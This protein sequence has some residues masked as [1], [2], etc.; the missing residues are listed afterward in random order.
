MK[1]RRIVP[2]GIYIILVVLLLA[3]DFN[4]SPQSKTQPPGRTGLFTAEESPFVKI[5]QDVLP[6]V[7]NISAERTAEEE[8][9]FGFDDR[10]KD[11]F[12][13]FEKFFREP[14]PSSGGKEKSLGSGVVISD[15]GYILTN[16]HMVKGADKIVVT[17]YDKTIYRG[18][19]VEIVGRDARTDLAVLKVHADKKFL[20]A[21]L[22]DSDEIQVGDWAVAI[23]SPLGFR[24]SVT[25]G[26]ISAKGRS[27]LSLPEGPQQQ[28]FIQTDA[29]INPGNSGGPL[30]NM[31][32][33]VI[34]INSAIASRTGYWQGIG[35]AIPINLA[36][37][38]YKQLV[39]KG[40]V[41]R[42]WLGIFL[43]ELSGD[44]IEA[45]GVNEGVL[46]S[47]VIEGSPAEKAGI[48]VGDVIVEFDGEK[49]VSI[50]QLQGVVSETS[51]GKRVKVGILKDGRKKKLMVNTGEMPEQ[52]AAAEVEEKPEEMGWLGLTVTSVDNE[53]ARQFGV[54]A[55]EGI[56]VIRVESN[57]PAE[58]AGIVPGDLLLKINR[59]NVKDMKSYEKIKGELE[60]KK[61]SVLFLVQRGSR[62]RFIAVSPE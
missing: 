37:H 56:L 7:V 41:V 43:Q 36:K 29:S 35:F 42:G 15:D 6:S 59:K 26:V 21:R 11:F 51:P 2:F 44:L 55:E 22:G 17:F 4:I 14:P 32:G 62:N 28:D 46:V 13:N 1:H 23:G 38:V 52:F 31:K 60:G 47:E 19:A 33:E 5:A 8:R 61:D 30:L 12:K 48:E 58:D 49:I 53:K 3:C 25:V 16:N 18:N 10:F 40:K 27:G 9:I 24:G 34:G 50:P 20:P 45:L 57:S 39:E 54:E